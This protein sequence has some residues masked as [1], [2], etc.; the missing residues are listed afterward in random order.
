MLSHKV[1]TYLNTTVSVPSS[2]LGPPPPPLLPPASVSLPRNQRGEGAHLPAGEEVGGIELHSLEQVKYTPNSKFTCRSVTSSP[3]S[4]VP[5]LV[6]AG[7]VAASID[8]IF[9]CVKLPSDSSQPRN[10][11]RGQDAHSDVFNKLLLKLVHSKEDS[12]GR[13]CFHC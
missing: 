3:N 1:H 11:P 9:C 8:A 13:I 4:Q 12:K 10:Y 5:P 2:E 6:R 7:T